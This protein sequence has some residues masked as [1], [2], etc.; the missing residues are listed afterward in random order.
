M[1]KRVIALMMFALLLISFNIAYAEEYRILRN[2]ETSQD[3]AKM[4]QALIDLKF[5]DAKADGKFG[6]LTE[7]AVRAFQKKYKLG[8]DGIAG[9]KTLTVLYEK[10]G[11][12]AS[13]PEAT[14][15]PEKSS[16]PQSPS[17]GTTTLEYKKSSGENV[18]QL[19]NALNALG[20]SCGKA[21]GK[22]G[23]ATYN[24]VIAFQK[25]N[26][27]KADG[28]AGSATLEKLYSTSVSSPA[29]TT[30]PTTTPPPAASGSGMPTQTL[31]LGMR[32][33][34][35]KALQTKLN[36][37]GYPV[38][39]ADGVYGN[40]TF[41]AVKSVQTAYKLTADGIAGSKTFAVLWSDAAASAPTPTPVPDAGYSS[42]FVGSKGDAVKKMQT[43]L[44]NLGYEVAVDG[45]FGGQSKIAVTNFQTQNGL[46]ITGTAD[47]PTLSLLYSGSAKKYTPP[48]D[49][50]SASG[51]TGGGPSS[52][53]VQLLHWF[54]DVKPTLRGSSKL[55][56]YD[57]AS[58][59]NW[60]LNVL[61]NGRHCDADPAS[62]SDTDSLFKAFGNKNTWT[63][64]PVYVKLPDGR[65]TLAS[66]HNV[67][68]LS[69]STKNNGFDGH[70]CVHFLR[71]MAEAEKNDPNY[72]VSNQ[73]TIRTAWKNLTGKTYEEKTR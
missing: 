40:K 47:S 46:P 66:T 36:E 42:L 34:D 51:K 65:W 39:T 73:K 5:L 38:G 55:F 28:K 48:A 59:Q 15:A 25:A 11:V 32:G 1:L 6:T 33:S 2:G 60:T 29:A 57:P 9:S 35:V 61:S 30:P 49:A 72:G 17:T 20:Y 22:F 45:D 16:A 10:A 37:K 13:V 27:L 71:D 58:N 21:D 3:V 68:H 63:Q 12:A 31:R 24:A 62:Q 56:A 54:D 43:A 50:P 18:R 69:G 14:P 41:S 4:Q 53:Q 52:G 67:P 26:G 8:V 44:K 23:S 64:K 19:Q 70:L 7:N